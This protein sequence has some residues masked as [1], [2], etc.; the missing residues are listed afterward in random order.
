[1]S[2]KQFWIY[3]TP[4]Q[5]SHSGPRTL[6]TLTQYLKITQLLKVLKTQN[7]RIVLTMNR[8]SQP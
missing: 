5:K 3:G 8:D 1:M 2:I 4:I 6:G 7:I